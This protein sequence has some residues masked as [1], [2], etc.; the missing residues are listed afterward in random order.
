MSDAPRVVY[1]YP[2]TDEDGSD[3]SYFIFLNRHC[4]LQR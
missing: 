4:A 1:R 2:W 3:T